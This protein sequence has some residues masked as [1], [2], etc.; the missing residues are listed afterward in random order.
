[1][2]ENTCYDSSG[3]ECDEGANDSETSGLQ[4][5][6]GGGVRIMYIVPYKKDGAL[7][8]PTSALEKKWNEC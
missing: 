6:G 3:R 4:R 2:F 7:C 5:G 1:M 8:S